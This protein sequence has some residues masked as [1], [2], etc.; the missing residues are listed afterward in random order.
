ME[1]FDIFHEH[2]V[3]LCGDLIYFMPIC[4]IL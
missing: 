3:Y 2:L 1:N 4:Y